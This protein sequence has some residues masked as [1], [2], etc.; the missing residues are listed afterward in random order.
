[1]EEESRKPRRKSS[2]TAGGLNNE[3]EPCETKL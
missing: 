1:M 2:I 3:I